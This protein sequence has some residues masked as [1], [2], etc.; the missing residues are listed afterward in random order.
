MGSGNSEEQTPPFQLPTPFLTYFLRSYPSSANAVEISFLVTLF[1]LQVNGKWEVG[2][3]DTAIPVANSI[4][5]F[6]P[7]D[8][9]TKRKVK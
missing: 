9:P 6:I 5:D 1:A 7:P 8:L 2:G 3:T 4:S